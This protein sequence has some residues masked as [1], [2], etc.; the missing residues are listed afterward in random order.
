ME[1]GIG[2][3]PREM[4]ALGFPDEGLQNQEIGRGL[5]IAK[6]IVKMD[7]KSICRKL[8]ARAR[9]QAVIKARTHGLC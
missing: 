5:F 3:K 2:Q 8:G 9:T 1:A 6:T 7:V 4:R